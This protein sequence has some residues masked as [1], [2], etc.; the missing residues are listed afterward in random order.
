MQRSLPAHGVNLDETGG[1]VQ[2]RAVILALRILA[3]DA[4]SLSA[5]LTRLCGHN[6][7]DTS[8]GAGSEPGALVP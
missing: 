4:M 1:W 2:T 6:K 5:R 7:L 8:L 3:A